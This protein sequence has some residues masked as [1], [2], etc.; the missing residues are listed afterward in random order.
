MQDTDRA[1]FS[2]LHAAAMG[3]DSLSTCDF[4]PLDT[5]S[6]PTGQMKASMGVEH[7]QQEEA[8]RVNVE[9]STT[10]S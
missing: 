6:R 1:E 7:F 10:E 4:A 3:L 9:R 2:S 8:P 5:A